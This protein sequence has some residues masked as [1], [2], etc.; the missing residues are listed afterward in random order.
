MR[1]FCTLFSLLL[2]ITSLDA[3]KLTGIWRG[4]F[5][6]SPLSSGVNMQEE[7]YK[8]EIQIEQLSNNSI[9]GVTYSYK[10]TVFYGKAELKG[11]LSLP[12]KSLIVK[13]TK[14]I[15]LK[16][17]DKS[18][19]CLMTCYL[20]Y[21]K[22]GKLEVLEGTFIS[23]NV[24]D[25]RDC[26]SGKIYLEKVPTTDFEKEPFLIKKPAD[27]IKKNNS[28]PITKNPPQIP[29]NS[30][31][32]R[33]DNLAMKRIP[34]KPG[35]QQ[36]TQSAK[37][38]PTTAPLAN[39]TNAQTKPVT[40]P[41]ASKTTANAT[42]KN[43]TAKKEDKPKSAAPQAT[44]AEKQPE[45]TVTTKM[46]TMEIP[47]EVASAPKQMPVPRVLIERENKLVRTINTSEE[48]ITIELYDNGSI[49][50]DTITVYHN[51]EL[52]VSKAKLVYT[53]IT[54]KIKGMVPTSHHEI[55][56]V[57]ENLGDIPPNSALMVVKAGR[58]RYEVNL[59]STETMNAKVII[60]YIPKGKD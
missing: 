25:K 50:N 30:P 56:V 3:Q 19:P 10:S 7:R 48:N 18:E 43:N 55:V 51:N 13:E 5:T 40:K 38:T 15:D 49:D 9:N 37:Q 33:G 23:T 46:E 6:S 35:T 39:K 57:A 16:I 29:G 44:I 60:N 42:N 1:I 54:V 8:Y 41:P 12:S 59:A 22:M 24:K 14:L 26:G 2:L 27:T 47:K 36:K 17:S 31:K 21:T 52:V 58:E 4:Y 53:P 45:Q 32:N 34:V 20:D 28:A 11:I